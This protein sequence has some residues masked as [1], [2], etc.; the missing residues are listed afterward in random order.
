MGC[1]KVRTK[2]RY[3]DVRIED[4]ARGHTGIIGDTDEK[5]K[6]FVL[7]VRLTITNEPRASA[8]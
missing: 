4:D 2:A 1:S 8:T 5:T 6:W 3:Q 7:R